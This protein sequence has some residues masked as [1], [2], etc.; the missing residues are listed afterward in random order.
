MSTVD[1]YKRLKAEIDEIALTCGRDPRVIKLLSVTKNHTWEEIKPLYNEGCR[2]F[3]ENRLQEALNKMIYTPTDCCWHFIG[4]LQKNKV[5]KVLEKFSVIHSVDSL[6]LAEKISEVSCECN[7]FPR[8]FLQVNTSG[9]PSKHGMNPENCFRLFGEFLQLKN[10]KIRGLMTM[11]PFVEESS[12]VRQTFA[13]LR[14]LKERI[15]NEYHPQEFNELSMG[16]SHD[17][18]WAIQEGATLLRI[19]SKIWGQ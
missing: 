2:E 12:I 5:K 3:G 18:K 8:I 1:N 17:Y 11:A 10:L 15:T 19:G 13:D 16:M 14:I 9:E 4:S 6:D 7:L